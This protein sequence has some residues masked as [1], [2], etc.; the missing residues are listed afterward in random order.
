MEDVG[1]QG[2]NV[3]TVGGH[4]GVSGEAEKASNSGQWVLEMNSDFVVSPEV[5]G[6]QIL[7][8]TSF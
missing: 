8:Q 4:T 2:G 3:V 5:N 7:E 1:Q 6:N